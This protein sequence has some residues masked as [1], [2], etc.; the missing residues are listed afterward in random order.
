[1]GGSS[2]QSKKDKDEKAY[3]KVKEKLQRSKSFRQDDQE[4]DLEAYSLAKYTVNNDTKEL[5]SNLIEMRET[6]TKAP[7]DALGRRD[8]TRAEQYHTLLMMKALPAL[9]SLRKSLVPKKMTE[10]H[11]WCVPIH[12]IQ[13]TESRLFY[14]SSMR[15]VT[16]VLR[17]TLVQH[18]TPRNDRSYRLARIP[19]LPIILSRHKESD[20][21]WRQIENGATHQT[22]EIEDEMRRGVSDEYRGKVWMYTAGG[23]NV[24]R[25]EDYRK[26][27]DEALSQVFPEK[28]IIDEGLLNHNFVPSGFSYENGHLTPDGLRDANRIIWVNAK[29][30]QRLHQDN[31]RFFRPDIGVNLKLCYLMHFLDQYQTYYIVETHLRD[32]RFTRIT[33]YDIQY[34]SEALFHIL[35]ERQPQLYGLM[36][37]LNVRSERFHDWFARLFITALP[38]QTALSVFTVFLHQGYKEVFSV[39]LSLFI[40]H[41]QTLMSCTTGASFA[42]TLDACV[43]KTHDIQSLMRLTREN[44]LTDEYVE[45]QLRWARDAN[46]PDYEKL[47]RPILNKE[48]FANLWSWLPPSYRLRDVNI[49]YSTERHGVSMNTLILKS[50]GKSPT[51]VIVKTEDFR[52]FGAFVTCTL[53]KS[54]E[55]RGSG[56]MFLFSLEPEMKLYTWSQQNNLFIN[57]SPSGIRIGAGSSGGIALFIYE[58]RCETFDNEGPL[59]CG[60]KD[61]KILSV[62]DNI[63][64]L[65]ETSHYLFESSVIFATGFDRLP[66]QQVSGA[67]KAANGAWIYNM[68]TQ[69]GELNLWLKNR[70]TK[71]QSSLFSIEHME[72]ELKLINKKRVHGEL[73]QWIREDD[74]TAILSCFGHEVR[75]YLPDG[76]GSSFFV[77]SK[78]PWTNDLNDFIFSRDKITLEEIIDKAAQLSGMQTN[79]RLSVSY[80]SEPDEDF[81]DS[82][83]LLHTLIQQ[84]MTASKSRGNVGYKADSGRVTLRIDLR[85]EGI[86]TEIV[87]QLGFSK[88][89]PLCIVLDYNRM[90]EKSTKAPFVYT[91]QSENKSPWILAKTR[92]MINGFLEEQYLTSYSPSHRYVSP[93][94]VIE[95]APRKD[96]KKKVEENVH[97]GDLA[98]LNPIFLSSLVDMGYSISHAQRALLVTGDVDLETAAEW[99]IN[100]ADEGETVCTS[101]PKVEK[102][103]VRED[104]YVRL[105]DYVTYR[106]EA[107]YQFCMMCDTLHA[108]SKESTKIFVCCNPL[109]MF[110]FDQ[111][112][113]GQFGDMSV[114]AFEDCTGEHDK[115][116]IVNG[117]T[118]NTGIPVKHL[119]EMFNHKYLPSKE[120]FNLIERGLVANG[121]TVKGF[122]NILRLDLATRFERKWEEMRK[123][124]PTVKVQMVYHGTRNPSAVEGI[125][126][127]GLLVPGKDGNGVAHAT[128]TGYWGKGIYTSPDA[129]LSVGYMS[130]QGGGLF[131]CSILMGK[132]YKCT[133][134][135][136]GGPKMDGYDSH[137]EWIVFDE[138]QVLPDPAVQKGFSGE[139]RPLSLR[140]RVKM[141]RRLESERPSVRSERKSLPLECSRAVTILSSVYL[142]GAEVWKVK[143]V[144][145]GYQGQEDRCST[146]MIDEEKRV[147]GADMSQARSS[148]TNGRGVQLQPA[149]TEA[150]EIARS[151]MP[152]NITTAAQRIMDTNTI[153]MHWNISMEIIGW[154]NPS[155][156]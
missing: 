84:Q 118:S 152:T 108:C 79:K 80:D 22:Q 29:M 122:K 38:F 52:I 9:K 150:T 40:L 141:N 137:S 96:K 117:V 119:H 139:G 90:K 146:S 110:R 62:E 28:F 104:L 101:V 140:I 132:V 100:N 138:C 133:Q 5:V 1:M 11:F 87:N 67:A 43:K 98:D 4:I 3:K 56:E 6:W 93:R 127:K 114:C 91:N 35:S 102:G 46:L 86:P 143:T 97:P 25:G 73:V 121:T 24:L 57:I 71:K 92:D 63:H 48:Q 72:E 69:E 83:P 44:R 18:H 142:C 41:G 78:A 58:D 125:M 123:R 10:E 136:T 81:K 145:G 147:S 155:E 124:D 16:E 27:Y 13:L 88:D 32:Q 129:N 95:R 115:I 135:M 39:A 66:D 77:E 53:E 30:H 94:Y 51:F 113:Q 85:K 144:E 26:C 116:T 99:C 131:V 2:H 20:V 151:L 120:I 82:Y 37:R 61:F 34:Y 76:D 31:N 54:I 47:D 15:D 17:K 111:V 33:R 12:M 75:L 106:L 50:Q 153:Y 126:K 134:M 105:F 36:S 148:F 8:L 156:E 149:S 42:D 70:S 45:S 55:F 7:I 128:D 14:F 60:E 68:A 64:I 89:T 65:I 130:G 21:F 59:T 107:F 112:Y 49:L 74:R 103:G 19:S 109:C 154:T 23:V